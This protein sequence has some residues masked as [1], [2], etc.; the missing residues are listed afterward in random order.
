MTPTKFL[1]GQILIIL[2]IVT[3][4]VWA[5]TQWAAAQ[6]GYQPQLGAPWQVWLG[7]PVYR[8]WQLFPW[9]F[10]YEAYA[11]DVFHRCGLL[12][13]MSGLLGCVAAVLGSIW[14]ARQSKQVT[15]YGSA[16]WA[17]LPEIRAAVLCARY[18]PDFVPVLLRH[19]RQK[20]HLSC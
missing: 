12:A 11:P 7:M 17:R 3:G 16:R 20:A 2:A 6:L 15:T 18:D 4:G 8:P 19:L 13:A 5:S 10:S 9:W 14:R 1:L